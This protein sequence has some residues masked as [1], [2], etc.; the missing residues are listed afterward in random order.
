[1]SQFINLVPRTTA[2]EAL[3]QAAL[4]MGMPGARA[5]EEAERMLA[6]FELGEELWDSYAST[7]SGGE[8]L[9]LNVARAMVRHPQAPPPRRADG[10][11][12]RCTRRAR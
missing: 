9:R 11:P 2:M 7:F 5:R 10:E 1:M 6:H 12:R 4:E 3:E 8:K